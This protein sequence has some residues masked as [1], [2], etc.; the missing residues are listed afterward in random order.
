VILLI[1]PEIEN[2]FSQDSRGFDAIMQLRGEVYRELENRRT[3]RIK[4][5]QK[6]YFIKQHYGVGWKEIFKNLLQ[7]RLPIL[8]AENEWQAIS[9]LQSLN[10]KTPEIVAYG[11]RGNNPATRQSFLITKELTETISLEDFCNDWTKNPPQFNTKMNLINEVAYIA[12]MMHMN[13]I[14][15]R[16]FYIC[17]FMVGDK[18]CLIDLHRA[19]IRKKIPLRWQIKDLA[20]LYFSTKEIGLTKGDLY[21]FIKAYTGLPL[22]TALSTQRE[23]W[24]RVKQRG[25]QLYLKHGR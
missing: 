8:S 18:L 21:R 19:Q 20:G 22:R 14:N 3:Q 4:I 6:N 23:F 25:E 16:D 12:R 17:H 7:C 10:I 1:S 5:N 15:H 24:Q 9:R 11:C 2:N 13:G